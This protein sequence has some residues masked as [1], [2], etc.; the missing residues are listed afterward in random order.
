MG[1]D[2]HSEPFDESTKTKLALFRGYIREWLPVFLA[3]G[4]PRWDTIN[5]FDYFAGPG[6]D[7][8]GTEGTPLILLGEL[9][10]YLDRISEKGLNVFVYLNEKDKEKYAQ[11]KEEVEKEKRPEYR[12][13]V[14]NKEFQEALNDTKPRFPGAANLV[15]ID[16]YGVSQVKKE[17]FEELVNYAR[18]DTAFDIMFFISS[19]QFHRFH[20]DKIFLQFLDMEKKEGE[21]TPYEHIHRKITERYRSLVPKDREFFLAPF[22]IKK[23]PNIRGV[24]FGTKNLLGLAKFLRACWEIDQIHG[25]ANFDIDKEGISSD[26]PSLFEEDNKPKKL[27][28]FEGK[29]KNA[30]SSQE[31]KSDREI[32]R[33]TL[34]SGVLPK[35]ANKVV[36]EMKSQGKIEKPKGFSI[37]NKANGKELKVL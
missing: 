28:V 3:K 33:F 29:L 35:H 11:L 12:V 23:G 14:A 17:V 13:K 2:L 4:K 9:K 22:S 36:K 31:L 25:E 19:S 20:N 16:Q 30:I 10:E 21:K 15:L 7:P 18:K 8:E 1:K 34:E 32:Y 24:I 6:R 27:S 26:Q 5:V 37:S